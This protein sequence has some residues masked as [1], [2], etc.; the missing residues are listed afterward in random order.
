MKS[1]F[2]TLTFLSQYSPKNDTDTDIITAF[3]EKR[4]RITPKTKIF[5]VESIFSQLDVHSFIEWYKSGY[6]ALEIAKNDNSLVMLGCCNLQTAEIIGKLE[7]SMVIP[8]KETVESTQLSKASTTD[9]KNFL[10]ALH[11]SNLQP[12]PNELSLEP[13]YIPSS[14]EKVFFHSIDMSTN[15]IGVV[16]EVNEITGS[17]ELYCYSIYPTKTQK[18]RVGYSMH[19]LDIV[20]LYEY[21]F[22]PLLENTKHVNRFSTED[23]LSAYRRMRRD[24]EKA[25]VVWRDKLDRIEP[26]KYKLAKGEKYWYISDK[27]EIIQD[28]EKDT[29]TPQKRYLAGNYFVN[30]EAASIMLKKINELIRDYLASPEWPKIV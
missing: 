21:I 20:N 10:K 25:G 15:G 13:K 17:V 3:L 9:V 24:L 6:T 7:G 12:N 30:Y 23:G 27:L 11:E 26:A 8:A 19:E 22:E 16:R 2:Q 28:V 1:K 5:A 4:Y 18:C 29:S 14:H